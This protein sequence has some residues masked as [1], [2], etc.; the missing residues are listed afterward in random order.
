MSSDN[1]ALKDLQKV[2]LGTRK[3]PLSSIEIRNLFSYPTSPEFILYLIS[4]L[5][6][7]K[8]DPDTTLVQSILN[9]ND[10]EDLISV[11]LAL[12]YGADPNLYVNAP[13]V[14]DIH[15]LGFTYMA[16][17]QRPLPVLN[18][19][20]IMLYQS[21]SSPILPIFDSK[22]GSIKKSF[23]LLN[24]DNSIMG[25]NVL[26]WLNDTGYDTILPL[27]SKDYNSVDP[28]FLV[29]IG[30]YLDS[31][32]LIEY[33]NKS[34]KN[35]G[36]NKENINDIIMAHSMN[37]F[38]K[39]LKSRKDHDNYQGLLLSIKYLNLST[40]E[41]FVNRGAELTYLNVLEMLG[42]MKNYKKVNDI[43][44]LG[45]I[46]SMLSYSVSKG[47]MLDLD[48]MKL[49]KNIDLGLYNE[50]KKEY[51]QPK[52]RKLCL[53][54][55]ENSKGN[56]N[57]ND[58]GPSDDL[59]ILAFSL[60]LNPLADKSVLCSQIKDIVSIDPNLVKKAITDRQKDR[61]SSSLSLIQDYIGLN[62]P[63]EGAGKEKG[64]EKE[65]GKEKDDEKKEIEKKYELLFENRSVMGDF[66]DNLDVD[67]VGYRDNMGKVWVF[68][69]PDFRTLIDKRINPY[70]SQPLPNWFI[71]ELERKLEYISLFRFSPL[72][73]LSETVLNLSK[74]DIISNDNYSRYGKAFDIELGLKMDD[75]TRNNINN[76]SVE[77]LNTMLVK[78]LD[79]LKAYDLKNPNALLLYSNNENKEEY[80]EEA[81]RA[82]KIIIAQTTEDYDIVI[83]LFK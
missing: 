73:P 7:N 48:Q 51:E 5:N 54:N 62:K 49:L 58:K 50:M 78:V 59:S 36:E 81:L 42:M 24:P 66:Y 23:G 35:K 2:I 70:T 52:W 67:V 4:A 8:I 26:E 37:V 45:Q 28:S 20:I 63:K 47:L 44:S 22:G 21:G 1:I 30:T 34:N 6:N 14:G 71:K 25:R 68:V 72:V 16:L 40:Y 55:E 83:P 79:T 31:L 60:N 65:V 10:K 12:R 56:D 57:E 69:S 13:N 43:I 3:E 61:L 41:I 80:K 53:S 15:I 74:P 39:Y 17:S 32:E 33:N 38:N 82:F 77:E 64:D 18:A 76:M 29:L 19:I 9:A 11:A 46:N 27:I 75:L